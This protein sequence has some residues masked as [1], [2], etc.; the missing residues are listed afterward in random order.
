MPAEIKAFFTALA[1]E[2]PYWQAF[3]LLCLFTGARRGAVS[4]MEWPELDLVNGVWHVPAKKCKNKKPAAIALCDP[5]LAILE[6]RRA[7]RS[8]S[9][10]VF[11]LLSGGDGHL[12]DPRKSWHRITR[13]AGLDDL[14]IHDLRRS[15]GSWQA[16]LGISLAIIGKS[17]SHSDLQSTQVYARI[18]LDEVRDAVGR[19][20]SAM[21][22]K[23][24]VS[25]DGNGLRLLEVEA[26]PTKDD[27]SSE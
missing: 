25:V 8:G 4:A 12:V 15:Q 16:A 17:L 27:D 24:G 2:D 6:T 19:S 5:A 21:M 1:A 11:P 7:Q 3:Y 13:A 22:N 26:A 18:Q 9:P 20:S 10:W 14:R 23:A